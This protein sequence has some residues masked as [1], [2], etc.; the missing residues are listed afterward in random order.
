LPD[1]LVPLV[2]LFIQSAR[3]AVPQLGTDRNASAAKAM[4]LLGWS[5]RPREEAIIATAE[6]LLQLELLKKL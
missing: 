6:S 2:G 5:P 1:W 3:D 4:R